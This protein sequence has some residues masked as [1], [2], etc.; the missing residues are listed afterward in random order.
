MHQ[1]IAASF[2]AIIHEFGMPLKS[3]SQIP[4][5]L[6]TLPRIIVK[7]GA[8]NARILWGIKQLRE[9]VERFVHSRNIREKT[10][11]SEIL[12]LIS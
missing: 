7:S 12:P 2:F 1:Q 8:T 9:V 10:F 11:T 4:A 6:L 3:T 5:I